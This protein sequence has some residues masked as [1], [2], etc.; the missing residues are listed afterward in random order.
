MTNGLVVVDEIVWLQTH[1]SVALR[2]CACM[3]ACVSPALY[4]DDA[5]EG[6]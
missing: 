4:L 2:V 5:S 6:A 3:R 1:W